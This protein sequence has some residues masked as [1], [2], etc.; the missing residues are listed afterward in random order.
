MVPPW[1]ST[2]WPQSSSHKKEESLALCLSLDQT[3]DLLCPRKCSRSDGVPFPS[4]SPRGPPA[5][6]FFS[7]FSTSSLRM[8]QANQQIKTHAAL[9]NSQ[10]AD[11]QTRKGAQ[12][13]PQRPPRLNRQL[14][15][16][17]TTGESIPLLC[18]EGVPGLPGA[19]QSKDTK[20]FMDYLVCM[21]WK[22]KDCILQSEDLDPVVLFLIS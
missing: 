22:K 11:F 19:P 15:L 6:P 7:C 3:R 12:L 5:F 18:V 16:L 1:V 10:P 2:P 17:I 9:A 8:H 14:P 4:P 21:W 13:R 20:L